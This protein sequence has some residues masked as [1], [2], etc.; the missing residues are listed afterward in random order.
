[1]THLRSGFN[2]PQLG[3]GTYQV[4]Q[5]DA[6]NLVQQ[7]F[8]IGY[9]H[10]DTAQM[11]S[12]E[13]G[14]G[15]AIVESGIP[16]QS[17]FITTKLD[18]PN[19]EPEQVYTS[20]AQSLAKLRTDYVDLFLM[21]WPLPM[22]YDGDFMQTFA[23]ME[24][25]VAEGHLRSVGVSNFQISHLEKLVKAGTGVPVINQVEIHP[26]F[27]NR[28]VV[29]YCRTAGIVVESWSPLGRGKDLLDP[30]IIEIAEKHDATPAQVVLAW[31]RLEG[32]VAIPKASS[33]ARQRE[34]FNSLG[35]VLDDDD[36][37]AIRAL[38]R[39]EDGRMGPNPDVFAKM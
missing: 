9:R 16:R 8:A 18:N 5:K 38:D 35:V 30:V 24:D 4:A 12:N 17:L 14:V 10:I 2:I 26:Y 7:A 21:H 23:T 32:F 1:M 22:H 15:R 11:Y 29:E 19:H 25:L 27:Q 13:D 34:N 6:A 36:L 28:Q 37:A 31:H 20:F 33:L 39:G 3:F